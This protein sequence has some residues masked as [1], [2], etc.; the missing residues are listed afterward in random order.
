M[1]SNGQTC[2]FLTADQIKL[3]FTDILLGLQHLHKNK[4]IHRDLKPPNL[5]LYFPPGADRNTTLPR[6]LISDFGECELISEEISR[7]RSGGTGTLEYMPPELLKKD[8]AGNYLPNHSESVDLWS[9]GI[10]LYFLCFTTVPFTQ[11]EDV[12]A[13][14]LEILDF[15]PARLEF[16]ETKRVPASLRGLIFALL[17]KE[18]EKRPCVDQILR[19][20]ETNEP[21]TQVHVPPTT[22]MRVEVETVVACLMPCIPAVFIGG[23]IITLGVCLV[24]LALIVCKAKIG[25]VVGVAVLVVSL[26]L[27]M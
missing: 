23:P 27:A 16:P 20:F 7:M 18:A 12:D 14:R 17:S 2:R 1:N 11:T 22:E 13:L 8:A 5:L 6:V 21:Q 26:L 19:D 9:L 25:V 24:T 15:D 10:I 3:L 4:I